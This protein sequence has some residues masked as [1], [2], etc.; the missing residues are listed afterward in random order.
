M[1]KEWIEIPLSI[2][3]KVGQWAL[4]SATKLA[5]AVP[6]I[7]IYSWK[8]L[9]RLSLHLATLSEAFYCNLILPLDALPYGGMQGSKLIEVKSVQSESFEVCTD[10]LEV[11]EGKHGIL[12]GGS[13]DG[14]TTTAM[15]I[16]YSIGGKIRIY[17]ADAAADE[18]QGLEVIGRCADFLAINEA[19]RLDLE[20]LQ[21]R[22]I[23]RG[24]E[25]SNACNGLDTVTIAEEFPLLVGEVDL[26]AEWLIK[27]GKRGR[28]VRKFILAIAQNDTAANFGIEGDKGVIDSFRIIRLGKKAQAHARKLKNWEL[29]EWLKGDRSRLLADDIP[30]QLPPYREIQRVI[31]Q[32]SLSCTQVLPP[33][34]EEYEK[35][36]PETPETEAPSDFQ[37]IETGFSGTPAGGEIGLLSEILEAI[38]QERSDDWIAKNVI[39]A[40]Q[41]IGYPK[42]KEKVQA[43]RKLIE[44]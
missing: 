1:S 37:P 2:G 34:Q 25:G 18:W 5:V 28:R 27:H 13:G 22:T 21:T 29:E 39:M 41:S 12:I 23:K 19:M 6:G 33:I 38:A 4:W 15:Y 30:V 42:A 3:D 36:T 31:Q 32:N 14:K 8:Q 24:K 43:I 35:T 44:G 10:I 9:S 40:S 16:A 26:A 11:L 20:D 17:D 7:V